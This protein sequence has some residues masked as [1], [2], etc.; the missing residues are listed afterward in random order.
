MI[1]K[2]IIYKFFK[3][4]PNYRKMINRMVVFS[5]RPLSNIPKYKDHRWDLLEKKIPW[6]TYSGIYSSNFDV[7]Y[8]AQKTQSYN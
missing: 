3:D 4:S 7:C 5:N 2:L 1:N 6:G 8:M